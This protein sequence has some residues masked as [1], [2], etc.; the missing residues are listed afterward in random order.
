MPRNCPQCHATNLLRRASLCLHT[1]TSTQNEGWFRLAL[2]ETG[3][4]YSYISDTVVRTTPNLREKFDVI[5][6]PA[7]FF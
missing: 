2:E 7:N 6:F 1:W 3:V 5:L 4:P